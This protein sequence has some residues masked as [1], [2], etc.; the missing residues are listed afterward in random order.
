MRPCGRP[1][2]LADQFNNVLQSVD[3]VI[4]SGN[5]GAV[6]VD[7]NGCAN[8]DNV[9]LFLNFFSHVVLDLSST[10][11]HARRAMCTTS[12]PCVLDDDG[13]NSMTCPIH[14][15]RAQGA[16]LEDVTVRRFRARFPP[17]YAFLNYYFCS[18]S[19]GFPLEH[20]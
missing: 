18:N 2:S 4:G 10:P 20:S 1:R 12:C 15:F 6:G 9:G 17:I 8:F 19:A 16:T 13:C 11:P 14:I 3:V 5:P 7:M